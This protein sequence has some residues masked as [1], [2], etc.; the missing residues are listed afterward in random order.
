MAAFLRMPEECEEQKPTPPS[1]VV[2]RLYL[3]VL[4]NNFCFS[5]SEF[6]SVEANSATERV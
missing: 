2:V 4:I 5:P 3:Q 6:D 1:V